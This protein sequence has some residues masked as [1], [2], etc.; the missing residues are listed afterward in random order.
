MK[1]FIK[2]P[3]GFKGLRGFKV[4]VSFANFNKLKFRNIRFFK[5]P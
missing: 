5:E 3:K 2:G 1:V 4:N